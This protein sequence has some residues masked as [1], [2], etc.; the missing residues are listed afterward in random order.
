ML[1]SAEQ[2]R[3]RACERARRH[4]KHVY[5]YI[6]IKIIKIDREREKRICKNKKNKY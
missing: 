5:V 6:N 4:T 2:V 1:E 3:A